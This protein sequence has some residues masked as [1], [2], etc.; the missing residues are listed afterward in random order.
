MPR[1][2][3]RIDDRD[4]DAGIR[5][6][7]SSCATAVAPMVA[8]VRSI[9]PTTSA[10][11][12]DARHQRIAGERRSA[13]FGRSS[14]DAVDERQAPEERPPRRDSERTVDNAPALVTRRMTRERPV[15]PGLLL[16][17]RIELRQPAARRLAS[18][19]MAR[20]RGRPT[21][22]RESGGTWPWGNAWRPSLRP[23]AAAAGW[24]REQRMYP[25][26]AGSRSGHK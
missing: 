24:G 17:Q 2:H 15:S 5:R 10:I 3:A 20:A 7:P 11:E 12:R 18:T 13:A 22:L 21:P 16:E 9:A 25:G 23:V 6:S 1:R 26:A 8:P 14:D 4:A 19:A